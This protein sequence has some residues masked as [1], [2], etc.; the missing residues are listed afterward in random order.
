MCLIQKNQIRLH[1]KYYLIFKAFSGDIDT[2]DT[3]RY[4]V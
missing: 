4:Y 2:D 1:L 3:G